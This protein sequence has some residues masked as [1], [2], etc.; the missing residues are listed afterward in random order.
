MHTD[1]ISTDEQTSIDPP[2]FSFVGLWQKSPWL[3]CLLCHSGNCENVTMHGLPVRVRINEVAEKGRGRGKNGKNAESEKRRER[4]IYLECL[5]FVP[6]S[7]FSFPNRFHFKFASPHVLIFCLQIFIP[8]NF[9]E[10]LY[11]R[12]PSE[13]LRAQGTHFLQLTRQHSRAKNDKKGK[14]TFFRKVFCC[15]YSLH[16]TGREF[17]WLRPDTWNSMVTH[18]IEHF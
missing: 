1:R 11:M 12:I 5:A 4:I 10:N 13:D 2:F 16:P 6:L 8:Q 7:Q 3:W 9:K 15:C 14:K 18:S 17:Y